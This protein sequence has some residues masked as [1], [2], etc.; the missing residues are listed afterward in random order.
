MRPFCTR[1][2]PR[3]NLESFQG[4]AT[5]EDGTEIPYFCVR[6]KGAAPSSP[7]L[8]YGYGGF[9]ISNTPGYVATVGASTCAAC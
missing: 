3:S 8:L 5:S 7:C 9:E 6:T 4:R 1:V 2:L